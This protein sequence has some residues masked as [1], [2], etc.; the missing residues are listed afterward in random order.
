MGGLW[1][2]YEL[3]TSIKGLFALGECNF[4][5]HGANRLGA[6]ALM[7]GLSDGYFVIPYTMQNYLSDQIQVPH[8]DTNAPEFEEAEKGVQAEID[9]IYNIKGDESVDHIHKKLYHIMWDYVG[10]ARNEKGLKKALAMLKDIRKEFNEHVRIPGDK[11]GLN[12]ELD[13]AIHLRD[14][15]TMGELIAYDALERNESC[16]GHFREESQTE[17]GEAKRDDEH[18]MYVAC[19]QYQGSD[20]VAPTLLKEP[21]NYQYIKVQVRNY[22]K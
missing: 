8:I 7:Q 14:F 13:K 10:M 22:K 18:Y 16:G 4:S 1:V 12:T 9:R 6:S 5:D 2:D 3:Q 17:E 21:L 19:W 11:E 15:I 20:D